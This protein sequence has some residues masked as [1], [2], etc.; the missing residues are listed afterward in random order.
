[1]AKRAWLTSPPPDPRILSQGGRP[2]DGSENSVELRDVTKRHGET[3]AVDR[4]SLTIRKGEFFSI[5]GPSGSG[6]TSTLRLLA[7]FEEPDS[8][9]ILIEGR[10]MQGIPPNR[11]PVN[12]VFQNYALF[13]HMSVA[14]NVAFGLEMKGLPSADIGPRVAEALAMVR[15]AGKQ[16]RLP[17][18]LS[19][20]EQQRVALARA[21]VNHPAVLLLDEPLAALDKQLRQ[22][23]EVELKALQERVGI[24]FIFVTHDQEEGL[25]MSDRLAIMHHGRLLQ[26]G[27]PEEVYTAPV[28][29]F[30]ANFIG[31]SNGLS[32]R[33]EE[34]EGDRASLA[35]E[36]IGHIR[37]P[38][39][40]GLRKGASVLVTIRPERVELSRDPVM[41][42]DQNQLVVRIA[43]VIYS[44]NETHYLLTLPN[45]LVWKARIA[46]TDG[47]AKR[48]E[49]G[50]SAYLKWG[51][52]QSVVLPE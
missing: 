25:T 16:E 1:M 42:G 39:Q 14:R 31:V 40:P 6:K 17:S 18:Q 29:A 41:D 8:G 15:L 37:A 19:G 48:F 38:V 32:G 11:R 47:E 34:I 46:N 36:G 20:G 51:V 10:P 7:G 30:V 2:T 12:L 5:L 33:V 26:V 9:E 43:K 49:V 21:L 28:S 13:P 45:N 3:V 22:E 4:L 44:G 23:M 27:T 52:G 35:V 24:T 50:E